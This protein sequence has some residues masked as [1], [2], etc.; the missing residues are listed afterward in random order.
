MR[1]GT[2]MVLGLAASHCTAHTRLPANLLITNLDS[3]RYR[4]TTRQ[5]TFTSILAVLRHKV[6]CPFCQRMQGYSDTSVHRIPSMLLCLHATDAKYGMESD[7]CADSTIAVVHGTA[8]LLT[9]QCLPVRKTQTR[10]AG[11]RACD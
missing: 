9:L 3:F 4:L 1:P 6:P 7:G 10:K 8:C 11:H 2:L 5:D